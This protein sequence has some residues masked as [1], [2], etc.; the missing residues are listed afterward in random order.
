[1]TLQQLDLNPAQKRA[2]MQ[3]T[4]KQVGLNLDSPEF[5]EALLA[6]HREQ[7]VTGGVRAGKSTWAA[8]KV[9]VSLQTKLLFGQPAL[10]WIVGPDYP[11][12]KAEIGYL[13]KWALLTGDHLESTEPDEGS[14][15]LD[16]KGG[17]HIETKSGKYT[18]R[19][20]SVAPDG[21][22]VVEAGQNSEELLTVMRERSMEKSCPIWYS[23]TLE[24]DV[25]KPNWAWY[26]ETA[27]KWEADRDRAHGSYRLPSWV[28]LSVYGDCRTATRVDPSLLAYCPDE[29]HGP[30]HSGRLHPEIERSYQL[31]LLKGDLDTWKRRVAGEPTG[32]PFIVYP[33]LSNENTDRLVAFSGGTQIDATGG[34]DYGTVHPTVLSVVTYHP[35]IGV[36]LPGEFTNN[37]WVREVCWNE[38]DPGDVSWLRRTQDYLARKWKVPPQKWGFDPNEKFMAKSFKAEAVSGSAGSREYRIGLTGSRLN[39][40]ALFFDI[41]GPGV[42]KAYEQMKRVHRVKQRSGELKLV[43]LDDDG[44][45]T[46]E[47]N[48]EM[49]DGMVRLEIPKPFRLKYRRRE[50]PSELRRV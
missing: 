9:W 4:C 35:R 16:I 27:E 29:N 23:G 49:K 13:R 46:I 5:T 45:A 48:I 10:Y 14:R 11:Q 19:L 1:M 44:A 21:I 17:I 22:L 2:F 33:Q 6:Q 50:S 30:T 18:E 25:L 41:T 26:S 42:A 37:A 32:L 24:S 36:Q 39:A 34:G 31:A 43:R 40:D 38:D 15:S 47:N 12:A 7:I 28:N 3:M 20:G 8:A